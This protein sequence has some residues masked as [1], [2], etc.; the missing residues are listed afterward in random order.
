M[1]AVEAHSDIANIPLSEKQRSDH[2]DIF[3]DDLTQKL[4][5]G[6]PHSSARAEEGAS[7]DGEDRQRQGCAIPATCG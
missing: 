5:G 7:K 2:L 6:N 1:K 3:L 4:E